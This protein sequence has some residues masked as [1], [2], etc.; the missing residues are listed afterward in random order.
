MPI[1]K[2]I[3][4]TWKTREVPE[5]FQHWQQTVL[6][7][8]PDW[9]YRLWNDEDART[10]VAT[11]YPQDLTL[12]DAMP[13]NIMRADMMRYYIMDQVGGFYM[14]RTEVTLARWRE[15]RRRGT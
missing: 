1:P 14:D 10:L 3:H 8:H 2:I 15:V 12:Y 6:D 7:H 4:Q 5:G 11:H 9:E 13:R